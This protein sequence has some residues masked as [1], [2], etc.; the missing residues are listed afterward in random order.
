[1]HVYLFGFKIA[2][3]ACSHALNAFTTND[4]VSREESY[5]LSFI[6]IDCFLREIDEME[7][8]WDHLDTFKKRTNSPSIVVDS[9]F[10]IGRSFQEE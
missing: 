8:W 10:E 6:K 3:E 9:K 1:M 4:S 5:T 7:T 2:K